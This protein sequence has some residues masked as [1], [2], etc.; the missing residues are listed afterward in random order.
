MNVPRRTIQSI[1]QYGVRQTVDT[2]VRLV[3]D[4]LRERYYTFTDFEYTIRDAVL[5][6]YG[7]DVWARNGVLVHSLQQVGVDESTTI[8]DIGAGGEGFMKIGKY[9]ELPIR[10]ENIT[11]V[12]IDSNAFEGGLA[13]SS[14]IGDGC[15]MPF[16]DKS[17][18]IVVSIDS[19]EH[20][21]QSKHSDYIHEMKRVARSHVF[22]HFPLSSEDGDFVG[23]RSD[24]QF[25][26]WHTE[27]TGS[28]EPN[29]AEHLTDG[30]PTYAEITNHFDSSEI[31]G[32]QNASVWLRYM[33]L[34]KRHLTRFLTG[35][36]YYFLGKKKDNSPPYHGCFIHSDLTEEMEPEQKLS[37]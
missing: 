15:E 32:V 33:K 36:Y 4:R 10:E 30:Y 27:Y 2:G 34:S 5:W 17:F 23:M 35:F 1:R 26:D 29:T 25:Q 24:E 19:L 8:L 20:V 37:N 18:D 11:R 21:P 13:G 14:V 6:P 16:K 31:Q 7:I 3:V 9:S 28:P 12:D 22:L